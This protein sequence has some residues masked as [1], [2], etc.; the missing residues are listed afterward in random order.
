MPETHSEAWQRQT[1]GLIEVWGKCRPQTFL[2]F[3]R[4]GGHWHL[5]TKVPDISWNGRIQNIISTEA[6]PAF[7]ALR[8]DVQSTHTNAEANLEDIFQQVEVE[9]RGKWFAILPMVAL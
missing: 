2:A 7:D 6:R 1:S 8:T 5:T 3:C 4:R 9:L